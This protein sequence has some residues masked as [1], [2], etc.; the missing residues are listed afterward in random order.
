MKNRRNDKVK[1]EMK[2]G[3]ENI[4]MLLELAESLSKLLEK[5]R[6]NQPYNFNIIDEL[7]ADENAHTRILLQLLRYSQRDEYPYLL[8]FLNVINTHNAN[9]PI[10]GVQHP[11]ILFN[12][13]NIDGLIEET[14]KYAIII[15][16][17]INWAVDQERQIERYYNTVRSHNISKQDIYVIYLTSDGA[18]RVEPYS[19]PDKLRNELGNRF[20]EM[21]YRE[22]VLPWLKDEILPEIK[23]KES[24][25]ESGVRQ[26]IDYL[27]GRFNL[28]LIQKPIRNIMK[29]YLKE[30][31]HLDKMSSQYEQWKVLTCNIKTVQD[32]LNGFEEITTEL[33]TGIVESWHNTTIQYFGHNVRNVILQGGYYQIFFENINDHNIHFEWYPLNKDAFFMEDN[34]KYTMVL[35]VEGGERNRMMEKI[36][37]N[38]AFL[39]KVKKYSY[40]IVESGT[41][42]IKKDYYTSESITDAI[43]I[44]LKV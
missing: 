17:K 11:N 3:K 28:R 30:E 41:T 40:N 7:H 5:E 1:I 15:E 4:S 26:Y 43:N 16:N 32:L 14:G 36:M 6:N 42:V 25:I 19:L 35:H 18:K 31:L 39:D 10:E 13:Q 21:N 29:E 38:Y 9:F 2:Y 24:L 34:P 33:A 12:K 44:G 37:R 27:D 8:S 23:L 20:I 22:D